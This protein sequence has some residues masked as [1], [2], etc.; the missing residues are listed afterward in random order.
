MYA[1]IARHPPLIQPNQL[2]LWPWF[3]LRGADVADDFFH[4]IFDGDDPR[5]A[6]ELI[7]DDR[8]LRLRR[9]KMLEN[10]IE[11]RHLRHE[12]DRL[13]SIANRLIVVLWFAEVAQHVQQPDDRVQV[14]FVD[15]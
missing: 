5:R 9:S 13:G 11:R 6:S 7:D 2:R 15:W 10:L 12:F 3:I 14:L 8:N 4:D 1:Q